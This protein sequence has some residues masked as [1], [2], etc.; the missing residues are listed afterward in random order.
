MQ[1]GTIVVYTDGSKLEDGS[2]GCGWAIYSTTGGRER[3]VTDGCCYLGKKAEVVDAELHAVHE[4]LMALRAMDAPKSKSYICI[5]N[6]SAIT[7]LRDNDQNAQYAR[8]SLAVANELAGGGW[9]ILTLWNPSHCNVVG[10]EKADEMAK[11]GAMGEEEMGES[12]YACTTKNWMLVEA[13]RTLY[14]K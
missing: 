6:T 2:T 4:G 9:E 3:L 13:K 8:Q 5:D 1:E 12:F 14:R 11:R 7:N 10:N